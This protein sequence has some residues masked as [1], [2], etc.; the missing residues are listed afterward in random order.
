[1]DYERKTF[2]LSTKFFDNRKTQLIL[3][4]EDGS[5]YIVIWLKMLALAGQRDSNGALY[6]T[7]DVPYTPDE[8]STVLREPVET[9][10]K[11][12]YLFKKYSMVLI[13]DD[14]VITIKNWDK[15]Q[16]PEEDEYDEAS[17]IEPGY[18]SSAVTVCV[19]STGVAVLPKVVIMRNEIDDKR[20]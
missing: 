9:I 5:K 11:A 1:M 17:V 13:S 20:R 3:G 15:Y 19:D 8:L 14:G 2:K 4:M 10:V 16:N 6:V 7:D 18:A 12:L